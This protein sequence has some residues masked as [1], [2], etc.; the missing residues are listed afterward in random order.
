VN[1]SA[2]VTLPVD[3]N[4]RRRFEAAWR[5]DG[6]PPIEQFLPPAGDPAY[7]VTLAELVLIDLEFAWKAR[8]DGK[9]PEPTRVE[10]YLRRFPA[11]AAEEYR[12]QLQAHEADLRRRCD[13]K[14][15]A[16]TAVT[17]PGDLPDL[18]GHE[19]LGR[20]GRGGMGVV[21]K[22]RHLALN[23]VVAIK[24]L[25]D[26]V[27]DDPAA[28]AR[29]RAEAE[30]AARLRHPNIVQI[31]EVGEHRGRP[32][33][34]LEYVAGGGLDRMIG[35]APQAVRPAAILVRQLARAVHYAH[36]QGVVHRDLKPANVL[37]EN[38]TAESAETAERTRSGGATLVGS[39]SASS[40]FS[41]VD[42]VPKITDF[43]LAKRLDLPSQTRTGDVLGTPSYMA[44]EQARADR[45]VGP[46]ADVYAL[47]AILYECLT[48]RPPFRGVTGWATVQMVLSSEP[49][50]PRELAPA[51]P[52]DLETIC[53]K[54]LAKDPA[55]RYASAEALAD[56]LDRFLTDRPILARPVGRIERTRRWAKRN[57][58]VAGLSAAL[59]VLAVVAFAVVTA[60]WLRADRLRGAA[61]TSA[62]NAR[63]SQTRADANFRKA[64]AV[65]D[66]LLARVSE[67]RLNGVPH[68]ELVR[69]DILEDAL[70]YYRDFL[71][72]RSDD[73][74]VR[75]EAGR[76]LRKMAELERHLG[77][78][79][80]AEAHSPE[81]LTLLEPLAAETPDDPDRHREIGL[82][83][84]DRGHLLSL[85]GR[86][87]EAETEYRKS[88][89]ED[90]RLAAAD[91]D[92]PAYAASLAVGLI[93]WGLSTGRR[94][95]SGPALEEAVAILTRLGAGKSRNSP[96][97]NVRLNLGVA[98]LNLGGLALKAGRPDEAERLYREALDL[99]ERLTA[100]FPSWPQFAEQVAADLN[101]L[102]NVLAETGR[103]ADAETAYR[104]AIGLRQK[105]VNDFPG[106]ADYRTAVATTQID[107]QHALTAAGRPLTPELVQAHRDAVAWN[108]KLVAEF[109][110]L[111]GHRDHLATA[112]GSLARVERDLGRRREAE[113]AYRRAV[114]YFT[115][116][117]TGQPAVPRYRAMLAGDLTGLGELLTWTDR[118][119]EAEDLFRRAARLADALVAEDPDVPDYRLTASRAAYG[120]AVLLRN[121]GR[122]A[123]AAELYDRCLALQQ[124]LVEQV[125]ADVNYRLDLA[126]THTSRGIALVELGRQP[127]AERGYQAAIEIYDRFLTS[128]PGT[129]KYLSLKAAALDNTAESMLSRGEPAGAKAA[130]TQAIAL[131]SEA[132][133]ASPK[134]PEYLRF[135][136]SHYEVLARAE[137][138]LGDHTAA[139]AAARELAAKFPTD[140][141]QLK[142]AA[143]IAA[144]CAAAAEKDT[145][146]KELERVA[147]VRN[148]T[149]ESLVLLRR[150]VANGFR[151]AADLRADPH[152]ARLRETDVFRQIIAE[153]GRPAAK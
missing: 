49:V 21:Y 152:L 41:A 130:V 3:E 5:T 11:L 17:L 63:R 118:K 36:R 99:H 64:R 93:S 128:A 22:A 24:M 75:L 145:R 94:E 101:A 46:A 16:V 117:A 97:R 108:E 34:T 67:E 141:R 31:Y 54:C 100:E 76:A 134:N 58:V 66:Q 48:G 96:E 84:H 26:R 135:L 119:A 91:P 57:P 137:L 87:G 81:A 59:A 44:P 105:L 131:E 138:G 39:A 65:V 125:P 122:R 123:Q 80:Q 35:G 25:L 55:R 23:R 150:A 102:A 37:I 98:K 139:A 149:A 90:R 51:V 45:E 19:V 114:D 129:A 8:A 82:A 18:P 85:L 32:Y 70:R 53:L 86:G 151:D 43:G 77:R 127:E 60:L 83:H 121:T 2:Q 79:E 9:P 68:L 27:D 14:P 153:M 146:P 47:G 74:G 89:D 69:R 78:Y 113:A 88:V 106:L 92:D 136:A 40:A 73:P 143:G 71:A 147:A 104:R 50:P 126:T 110:E 120:R 6:P 112:L 52:R 95:V 111:P 109:P 62:E 28:H 103:L 116:L 107:L 10:E 15:G 29:F 33:F 148:Y 4:C 38:L 133:K 12:N 72:E 56:D 42:L 142:I 30:A 140:P 13:R 1:E 7:L 124:R 132:L 144:R 61:E 115:E 20:L